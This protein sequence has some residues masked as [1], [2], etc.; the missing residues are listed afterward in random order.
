GSWKPCCL[1]AAPIG[2]IA[3]APFSMWRATSSHV[4]SS[5][6]LRSLLVPMGGP[7]LSGG[8]ATQDSRCNPA[9]QIA[10]AA[11]RRAVGVVIG[12]EHL[13][14]HAERNS[15]RGLIPHHR[16]LR[17]EFAEHRRDV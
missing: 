7:L 1:A 14:E 5:M 16:F 2:R 8:N 6:K 9:M 4:M 13:A 17:G 15:V 12:R 11:R 10:G 3:D